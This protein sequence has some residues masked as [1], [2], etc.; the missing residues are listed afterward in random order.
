MHASELGLNKIYGS[1]WYVVV[2]DRLGSLGPSIPAHCSNSRHASLRCEIT[3]YF[4]PMNLETPCE[5]VVF[6]LLCHIPKN[7]ALTEA[8]AAHLGPFLN[9]DAN[10]NEKEITSL[11]HSDKGDNQKQIRPFR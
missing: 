9:I 3:S 1:V 11:S 2:E 4:R 5:Q 7:I 6:A 10:H 8:R